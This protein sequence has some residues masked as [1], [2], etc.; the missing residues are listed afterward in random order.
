MTT[1]RILLPLWFAGTLAAQTF[2]HL[3]FRSG[4]LT[5]IVLNSNPEKGTKNVPGEAA[6][7]GEERTVA[8][9]AGRAC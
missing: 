7:N 8:H 4:D 9:R 3:R 1:R 6:K 2:L 5:G